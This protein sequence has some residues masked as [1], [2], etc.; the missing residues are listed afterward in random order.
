M[1]AF[2]LAC[3]FL[4]R[5]PV[6]TGDVRP[7]Q[8]GPAAACFPLIGFALGCASL[9]ISALLT[10]PIGP[11]LTAC[12]IVA[13]VAIVSGG[14]HLDGLADWFDAV[15]GGRGDTNRMLE[16]MRDSR[17]GAHG[18]SALVLV[19]ITKIVALSE[20]RANTL[21]MGLVCAPTCARAV[22]VWLLFAFPSARK[23]GLG[24]TFGEQVALRHALIA[25]AIALLISLSFGV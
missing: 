4:T 19:L 15:G 3:A 13:F 1:K 9:A 14:L 21:H 16:I 10:E 18:A 12:L 24:Q 7:E 8:F 6:R 2:L 17:I 23:D 25:S 5:L 22:A 11:T 20:L